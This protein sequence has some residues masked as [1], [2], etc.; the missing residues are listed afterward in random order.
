MANGNGNG[1]MKTAISVG[2]VVVGFAANIGAVFAAW[3]SLSKDVAVVQTEV[4]A[5]RENVTRHEN[6][7]EKLRDA[8]AAARAADNDQAAN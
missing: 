4:A 1:H 6:Q 7:I 8:R 3:N 2:G 5:I